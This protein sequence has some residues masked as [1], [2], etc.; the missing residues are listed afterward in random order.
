MIKKSISEKSFRFSDNYSYNRPSVSSG[1]CIVKLQHSKTPDI[2][3]LLVCHITRK[4]LCTNVKASEKYM[5]FPSSSQNKIIDSF[6]VFNFSFCDEIR[7]TEVLNSFK[8]FNLSPGFISQPVTQ[9]CN[10]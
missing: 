4:H 9:M 7:G 6:P 5:N 2:V 1:E 8:Y 3:N 10:K